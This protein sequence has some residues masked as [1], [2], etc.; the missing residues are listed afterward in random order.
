MEALGT[1]AGVVGIVSLAVQVAHSA[2]KLHDFWGDA[3]SAPEDVG[4]IKSA[5]SLI[6]TILEMIST[7][8]DESLQLMPDKATGRDAVTHCVGKINQ[9]TALTSEL[10]RDLKRP[11]L[12]GKLAPF[13][14]AL[15]KREMLEL[16][17]QLQSDVVVLSLVMQ[18]LFQ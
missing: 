1:A 4:N 6:G 12:R 18:S 2:R 3:I 17:S 16:R 7:D 9:L 10:E 8:F 15:R 13:G 11:G 14:S 5:V